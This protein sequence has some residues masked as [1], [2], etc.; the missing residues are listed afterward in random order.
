M[1][2]VAA[3]L[4][5]AGVE[6]AETELVRRA[7]PRRV[8]KLEGSMVWAGTHATHT[9][10]ACGLAGA[11]DRSSFWQCAGARARVTRLARPPHGAAPCMCFSAASPPLVDASRRPPVW[12]TTTTTFVAVACRGWFPRPMVSQFLSC[13]P[14]SPCAVFALKYSGHFVLGDDDSE[15]LPSRASPQVSELCVAAPTRAPPAHHSP[16]QQCCVQSQ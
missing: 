7:A 5:K 2:E 14:L 10:C 3:E 9:A 8:W 1:V 13:R 16:W 4:L 6:D 12:T 15:L 11:H